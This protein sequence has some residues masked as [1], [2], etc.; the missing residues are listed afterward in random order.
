MKYSR[1][2]MLIVALGLCMFRV[3]VLRGEESLQSA[4]T[5]IL[6]G[7]YRA[8]QSVIGTLSQ[9]ATSDL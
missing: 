4:Y 5:A 7:D 9:E 3:E 2:L 6:K 8:G 1:I